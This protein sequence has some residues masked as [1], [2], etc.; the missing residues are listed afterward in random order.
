MRIFVFA[1]T[2][3]DY[4]FCSKNEILCALIS[5]FVILYIKK[6][7]TKLLHPN[8]GGAGRF[9]LTVKE[10]VKVMKVIFNIL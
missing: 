5:F 3:Y 7:I 2:N 4:A 1:T 8:Q 10:V 6:N 9:A